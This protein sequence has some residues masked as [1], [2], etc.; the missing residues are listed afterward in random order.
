LWM[1]I[2]VSNVFYFLQFAYVE[3]WM[4]HICLLQS[5]QSAFKTSL[6]VGGIWW[7]WIRCQ[8]W[9]A[10]LD[11]GGNSSASSTIYCRTRSRPSP[12]VKGRSAALSNRWGSGVCTFEITKSFATSLLDDDGNCVS[13]MNICLN[14]ISVAYFSIA[15]CVKDWYNYELSTMYLL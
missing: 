8:W 13:L 14:Y 5:W 9:S 4:V 2:S 1:V 12:R 3:V 6:H 15:F 11:I 7:Y 10:W